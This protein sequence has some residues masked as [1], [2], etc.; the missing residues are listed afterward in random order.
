MKKTFEMLLILL[1]TV[2]LTSCLKTEISPTSEPTSETEFS[3]TGLTKKEIAQY[4]V[5]NIDNSEKTFKISDIKALLGNDVEYS[6]M[7][8]IG[9]YARWKI[10]EDTYFKVFIKEVERNSDNKFDKIG[11]CEVYNPCI[12][13]LVN[14]EN[15]KIANDAVTI[16]DFFKVPTKGT[17]E[18]LENFLGQK[19]ATHLGSTSIWELENGKLCRDD[20]LAIIN[21][22][23]YLDPAYD[24]VNTRDDDS[25][26]YQN[27]GRLYVYSLITEEQALQIKE[28]MTFDEV[29]E[30]C[31][32]IPINVEG[33]LPLSLWQVEGGGYVCVATDSTIAHTD[34][35]IQK[36]TY[37]SIA[38]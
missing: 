38:T 13:E 17:V 36:V 31:K 27:V 10:D 9:S 6:I 14:E 1:L 5:E 11:E 12:Y 3:I 32:S 24:G 23:R 19:R 33:Y 18:E 28:G 22:R 26:L 2:S 30:I 16:E 34:A 4:L 7:Y 15:I 35:V 8:Y 25:E 21:H 29:I 37:C 20:A